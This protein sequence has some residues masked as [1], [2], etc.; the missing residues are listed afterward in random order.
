MG[1]SSGGHIV[2]L[3]AM[4]PD[5]PRYAALPLAEAPNVDAALDYLVLVW[6][7]LEEQRRRAVV[8]DQPPARPVTRVPQRPFAAEVPV[9]AD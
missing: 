4:R 1:N 2:M 6:P 7:I 5:D 3:S 9:V 8:P